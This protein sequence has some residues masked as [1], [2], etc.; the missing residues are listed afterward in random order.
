[1]TG[2]FSTRKSKHKTRNNEFTYLR[3]NSE[4]KHVFTYT[5]RSGDYPFKIARLFNEWDSK[6]GDLYEEA[7][8][9]N[10]VNRYGR[11]IGR[12]YPD[13]KV[14]VVVKPKYKRET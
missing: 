3:I 8:F 11:F 4:G 14:Y 7:G 13:Q 6:H 12:V 2:S 1:M 9:K 5:T 10:V